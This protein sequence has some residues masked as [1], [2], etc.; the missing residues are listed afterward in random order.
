MIIGGDDQHIL[1]SSVELFNWR[2]G[3]QCRLSSLPQARAA[4]CGAVWNG[5]PFICGGD[6]YYQQPFYC[7]M[8]KNNT[9]QQMTNHLL[10]PSFYASCTLIPNRGFYYFGGY[11][12]TH[13]NVSSQFLGSLDGPWTLGPPLFN[14]QLDA[15]VCLVQL[16]ETFTVFT[17]GNN[18]PQRIYSLDWTTMQYSL[19]SRFTGQRKYHACAK[20]KDSNGDILVA[21]AGG[22]SPGLEVWNPQTNVVMTLDSNFPPSTGFVSTPTLMTVKDSSTL[23][24]YQ[25]QQIYLGPSQTALTSQIYKFSMVGRNWTKIGQLLDDRNDFTVLPVEGLSCP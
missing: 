20:V 18:D 7:L 9:W 13:N 5:I 14:A 2:T 3:Q 16:N 6:S 10:I 22:N 11:P 12:F 15:N 25:A 21:V 4:S 19:H 24:Y 8:F 23:I 1:L 17:G